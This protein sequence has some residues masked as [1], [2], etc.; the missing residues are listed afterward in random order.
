M[1]QTLKIVIVVILVVAIIGVISIKRNRENIASSTNHQIPAEYK[2]ENL[3][4][5]GIPV[6]VDIGAETCIPCKE[7]APILKELKEELQGKI[8]IQFLNLDEYPG[9]ADE[10]KIIVKPTQIFFDASGEELFRH[11]GFYSKQDILKKWKELG[12]ELK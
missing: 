3:T 11:K 6:L 9:F 12:I 5:N 10:Y 7:M 1:N 2:V 8:V 4:G